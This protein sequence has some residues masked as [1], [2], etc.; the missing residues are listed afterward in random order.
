[1]ATDFRTR[2]KG[3]ILRGEARR[4]PSEN[5]KSDRPIR[6]YKTADG[7]SKIGIYLREL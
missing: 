4:L 1:M 6:D 3:R 2:N 5:W 7:E